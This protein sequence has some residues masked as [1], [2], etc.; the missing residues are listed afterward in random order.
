[1]KGN[2]GDD[3]QSVA[4][5]GS[6]QTLAREWPGHGATRPLDIAAKH[7][8]CGLVH[9]PP[10]HARTRKGSSSAKSWQCGEAHRPCVAQRLVSF[11]G[12][13]M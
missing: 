9:F 10:E 7:P 11:D 5:K 13:R 3:V 4:R 1:M 12:D 6:W 2:A 8:C